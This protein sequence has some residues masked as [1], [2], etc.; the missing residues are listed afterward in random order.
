[1][2]REAS[3]AAESLAGDA[4]LG[5]R[6][7]PGA[8]TD[9]AWAGG[10]LGRSAAASPGA[11]GGVTLPCPR[12]WRL[13]GDGAARRTGDSLEAMREEQGRDQDREEMVGRRWWWGKGA[14]AADLMFG[15][16]RFRRPV[17]LEDGHDDAAVLLGASA[18]VRFDVGV[19][20]CSAWPAGPACM[21][22][23]RAAEACNDAWPG[24]PATSSWIC[25]WARR[26]GPGVGRSAHGGAGPP[27]SPRG[28]IHRRRGTQH[29]ATRPGRHRALERECAR[30]PGK[31]PVSISFSPLP[32]CETPKSV[33]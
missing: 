14:A 33:N 24:G 28:T 26:R 9:L 17:A 18:R 5:R 19:I 4:G 15:G 16:R 21:R 32:N 23:T 2:G 6:A 1:L 8:A 29:V 30:V 11:L 31:A 13:H 22:A 20:K 12:Q 10:G 27:R 25:A 7:A 3:P